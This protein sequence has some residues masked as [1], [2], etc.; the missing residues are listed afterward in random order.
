MSDLKR[1][2]KFVLLQQLIPYKRPVYFAELSDIVAR[3]NWACHI[4]H[5]SIIEQYRLFAWLI[6]IKIIHHFYLYLID[7]D[8]IGYYVS[9]ELLHNLL[10]D[11]KINL[12]FCALLMMTLYFYK[13]LYF[14]SN[15]YVFHVYKSCLV[16]LNNQMFHWPYTYNNQQAALFVRRIVL[17]TINS[18]QVFVVFLGNL[19]D[20]S[21]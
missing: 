21:M 13:E 9:V 16:D 10:L 19:K 2:I 14:N 3:I 5:R 18:L 7:G 15:L 17:Y 1:F 4:K 11:R 8:D 12:I 6:I 20:Y